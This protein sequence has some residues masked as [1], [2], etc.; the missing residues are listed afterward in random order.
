MESPDLIG[1]WKLDEG[2]GSIAIDSSGHGRDA[3]I[4]GGTHVAAGLAQ[5]P[6]N[7]FALRLDGTGGRI[8]IPDAPDWSLSPS[9]AIT[10]SAWLTLLDEYRPVFHVFG[11]RVGCEGHPFYQLARDSRGFFFMTDGGAAIAD[12]DL[13]PGWLT[14]VAV[15]YDAGQVRLYID[16][17][18]AGAAFAPMSSTPAG[19]LLIG[20]SGSCPGEQTFAGIVDDFRVY[21]RALS[22]EEIAQLGARTGSLFEPLQPQLHWQV[23]H[24]VQSLDETALNAAADVPGTFSYDPPLGTVLNPGPATL[25]VHFEPADLTRYA[26]VDLSRDVI[27]VDTLQPLHRM[28]PSLATWWT[29]AIDETRDLVFIPQEAGVAVVDGRTNT[30]L[31]QIPL[32]PL[33]PPG[34]NGL[35]TVAID[36]A[37]SRVY[38]A[39]AHM[40]VLWIIDTTSWEILEQVEMPV[41]AAAA[42]VNPATGLLYLRGPGVWISP[43][44]HPHPTDATLAVFDP[45]LGTGAP[46]RFSTIPV[47]P[48]C[49]N[50]IQVN[51]LSSILYV[52]SSG[53]DP[54]PPMAVDIDPASAT[55]H[56]TLPP[57][58]LAPGPWI[59][60]FAVN[61]RTGE[62]YLVRP[63]SLGAHLLIVDGDRHSSTFHT[64][65]AE[66]LIEPQ[67]VGLSGV[68]I[69][70]HAIP[71]S[72]AMN[73][74]LNR[75]YVSVN[76]FSSLKYLIATI[77]LTSRQRL[78]MQLVPF[79]D[80]GWGA[81]PVVNTRANRLY[82]RSGSETLV[83]ED[84]IPH[85]S[86]TEPGTPGQPVTA[87]FPQASI[88]FSTV[89]ASGVTQVEQVQPSDINAS[90]PGGYVIDGAFAY[91]I[92]T[93]ASV[94]GPIT[95]CFYAPASDDPAGFAALRVLHG[96]NGVLVDRTTSHDFATRTICATVSSLS[97]FVI[98]RSIEPSY[99][100]RPLY[101]TSK[102]FKAGST[103]PVRLQVTDA[104]GVNLAAASLML[105]AVELRQVST[106]ASSTVVD[107]GQSNA[108]ADFRFDQTL[109]GTG[110]YIFNL[111]TTGLATGSYELM[112]T[113]GGGSRRY[114]VTV[115]IR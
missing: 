19:P 32:L 69:D 112:F 70:S 9:N 60:A 54:C 98:A 71:V 102:S 61:Q 111:K 50:Q 113:V 38:V 80:F 25:R 44:G 88:A 97:P 73:P 57:P 45:A 13:Q 31:H 59:E 106:T 35:S 67:M 40:P 89:N 33:L 72:L 15:T 74:T 58:M 103:A 83:L 46:G 20:T 2:S 100:I 48:R 51:P 64:V 115:Q 43:T 104:A 63:D 18:L 114:A 108:D 16:G 49:G 27:V 81:P 10:F 99:T 8:S 17:E 7:P 95:L 78:A 91:E 94:T 77:D 66:I 56:T 3:N 47:A 11:K 42:V 62:L 85:E 93:T 23:T 29:V 52:G 68:G 82:V 105:H 39:A 55:Y 14:H 75:A 96:E 21:R 1:H 37:S 12:R 26:P 76:D 86:V 92:T 28:D 4:S 90:L 79:T 6:S 101:D 36:S 84:R 30:V 87:E 5:I 34:D 24:V 65:L 53:T 109:G 107:A 110:G 22:A 41:F